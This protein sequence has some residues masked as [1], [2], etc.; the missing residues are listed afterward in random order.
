MIYLI[1]GKFVLAEEWVRSI[2]AFSVCDGLLI[3]PPYPPVVAYSISDIPTEGYLIVSAAELRVLGQLL[4][5][6]RV[7]DTSQAGLCP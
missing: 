3:A 1:S 2:W 7:Q 6:P 5:V 4:T